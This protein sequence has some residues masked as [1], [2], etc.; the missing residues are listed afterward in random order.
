MNQREMEELK[1]RARE[2]GFTYEIEYRGCGQCLV[3]AVQDALGIKND[4]VFKAATGFA[5][6]IGLNQDSACG[7]YAGGVMILSSFL[8]REKGNFGDP[9]NVRFKSFAL[10]KKLHD[11]FIQEYGAVNCHGIHLKIFGRPF[12]LWDPDQMAKFD[13]A[14]GHSDKCPGVVGR[15]AEWTVE[16]LAQEGLI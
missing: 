3:G 10:A 14:G 2:L 1:Q 16:L 12:Y 11:R 7:G 8:G 9:E 15:A 4:E 5:G 6:G 13:L